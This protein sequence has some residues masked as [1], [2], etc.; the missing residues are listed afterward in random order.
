MLQGASEPLV[1]HQRLRQTVPARLWKWREVA[2]W[3]WQSKGDHINVLELRAVHT[4]VKWMI[5]KRK[6]FNCRVIHLVDSLVVLHS[7]SR[8]RSSSR[9]LRR[10]LMRINALLLACNLHCVW[11]YVHTAQNPAN[12]PSRRLKVRKWGKVKRI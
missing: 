10:T 5:R 9:K 6:L 12:R 11:T 1:K 2:G 4:S 8:G 7:L 3:Q